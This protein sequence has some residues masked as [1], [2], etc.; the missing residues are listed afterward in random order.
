M[1]IHRFLSGKVNAKLGNLG[2]RASK[3]NVVLRFILVGWYL[4]VL[5]IV[6]NFFYLTVD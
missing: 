5:S 1:C 3:T 6:N 2:L 4:D